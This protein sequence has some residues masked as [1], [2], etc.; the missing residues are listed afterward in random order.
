MGK[1]I[2][3]RIGIPALLAVLGIYPDVGYAQ[4]L[5]QLQT[6]YS[7]YVQFEPVHVSLTLENEGPRP[8]VIARDIHPLPEVGFVFEPQGLN[9]VRR[10]REGLIL[11]NVYLLSGKKETHDIPLSA[12]YDL[13][14]MGMYLVRGVVQWEGR[15]YVS[16]P[17]VFHVVRGI[18]LTSMTRAV[19][20]FPE[21]LRTYQLR[22][23]RREGGEHLFLC[24]TENDGKTG[25]GA[26]ALGP[27]VRVH[28]PTIQVD[29]DGMVRVRHQRS[30]TCYAHTELRSLKETVQYV[31]QTFHLENGQP[32]PLVPHG[33][34]KTAR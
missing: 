34:E 33:E 14:G 28:L 16:P 19:P 15:E 7:E 32:Y 20:G 4:L 17:L 11:K 18:P 6:K 30:A 26:F 1:K 22:Y 5:V 9:E 13:S 12:W 3:R 2:A 29:A 31:Q 10:L 25:F 24:V 8:F 23:W 27:L 21:Q